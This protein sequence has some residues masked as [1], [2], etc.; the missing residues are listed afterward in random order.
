MAL[1]TYSFAVK[2]ESNWGNWLTCINL[3]LV[4]FVSF[5]FMCAVFLS[6]LG[7]LNKISTYSLEVASL[8]LIGSGKFFILYWF[9]K[10]ISSSM[11]DA[12]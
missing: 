11:Y 1:S 2:W 5:R 12:M 3:A 6:I 9:V 10:S 4:I 8:I 7:S